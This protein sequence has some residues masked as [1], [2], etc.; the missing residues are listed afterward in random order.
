VPYETALRLIE[1]GYEGYM[2]EHRESEFMFTP[3]FVQAQPA[4]VHRFHELDSR[5]P[6]PLNSYLRHVIARQCHETRH[7]LHK[8]TAPTLV[9]DGRDDT[10][11]GGTGNHVESSRDLARNIAGAELALVPGAHNYLMEHPDNHQVII[12]FLRRHPIGDRS[13]TDTVKERELVGA[14]STRE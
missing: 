6:T 12:D 13:R 7:L 2:R 9:I 8:I 1:V 14:T 11:G 5:Y 4:V 3:G 10:E